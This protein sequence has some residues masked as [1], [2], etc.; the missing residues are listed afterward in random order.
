MR[1]RTLL[2]LALAALAC[3]TS[4]PP[5][6]GSTPEPVQPAPA[7]LDPAEETG[8]ALRRQAELLADERVVDAQQQL[9]ASRQAIRRSGPTQAL[10]LALTRLVASYPWPVRRWAVGEPSALAMDP[11]G[12]LA[13][14]GTVDGHVTAWTL[15]EA[16]LVA[17]V[18][19]PVVGLDGPVVAVGTWQGLSW[20]AW[21]QD[22]EL[23]LRELEAGR[24]VDRA[25]LDG[26][27][28]E[29]VFFPAEARF[30]L[31][32][33]E[34]GGLL[35]WEPG[36]G[37]LEPTALPA[38]LRAQEVTPDGA[39][40][41]GTGAHS[42]VLGLYAKD[43]GELLRRFDGWSLARLAPGAGAVLLVDTE[44][45]RL[46][47]A[48]LSSAALVWQLDLPGLAQAWVAGRGALAVSVDAGGQPR[49]WGFQD[50]EPLGSLA[51]A[52]VHAPSP[53]LSTGGRALLARVD[54]KLLALWH[55]DLPLPSHGWQVGPGAPLSLAISTHELVAVGGENGHVGIWDLESRLRLRDLQLCP[56]SVT[57]LAFDEQG[58]WLAGQ[59]AA[60]PVAWDLLGPEPV[61]C[62]SEPA[63]SAVCDQLGRPVHSTGRLRLE[64]DPQGA[65]VIMQSGTGEPLASFP[66]GDSER[67]AAELSPDGA[68][69]LELDDQG[70]LAAWRLD[71]PRTREIAWTRLDRMLHANATS[72]AALLA[73][74]EL[75]AR[76][77]RW[78]KAAD[79]VGAAE[80]AGALVDPVDRVRALVMGGRH[81]SARELL[82]Q[83]RPALAARPDLAAWAVWLGER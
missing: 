72:G 15:P 81:D 42:G 21:Q 36:S 26:R 20:G 12:G 53:L 68:W 55:L 13:L 58:L 31:V 16:R 27:S 65:L 59:C 43:S 46:A 77:G 22:G 38:G 25:P 52:P 60:G 45:G 69:L 57:E 66:A 18:D 64:L 39:A 54:D 8:Y 6:P 32:A 71:E 75:A 24:E 76:A 9:E 41:L 62:T 40:A 28:V 2:P 10:D 48:E 1:I 79:L 56:S 83:L 3:C 67:L 14:V 34:G 47:R 73:Q 7:Q 5:P 70:V 4:E 51:H 17:G 78:T 49:L 80:R 23:V 44:G 19:G 37:A 11:L 63:A 50:G 29:D 30:L 74:A 61:L 33:L 35:Y 82:G